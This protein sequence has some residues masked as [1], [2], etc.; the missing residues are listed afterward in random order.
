M[1]FDESEVQTSSRGKMF[2]MRNDKKM[3]VFQDPITL[4]YYNLAL[5]VL[6]DTKMYN[7]KIL[8]DYLIGVN[9]NQLLV[10][11]SRRPL[12]KDDVM[13]ISQKLYNYFYYDFNSFE[14]DSVYGAIV[15]DGDETDDEITSAPVVQAPVVQAPERPLERSD[16]AARNRRMIPRNFTVEIPENVLNAMQI[17]NDWYQNTADD[18]NF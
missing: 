8:T 10:P 1:I 2:V 14:N 5:G 6:L 4:E 11:H 12:T 13:K 18:L 16:R 17:V 9:F 15:I 7:K 3:Y